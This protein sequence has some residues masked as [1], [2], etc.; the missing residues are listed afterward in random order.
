MG[1]CIPISD[2]WLS[3][4]CKCAVL[5]PGFLF[6][7]KTWSSEI[8]SPLSDKIQSDA[9]LVFIFAGVSIAPWWVVSTARRKIQLSNLKVH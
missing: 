6:S 5:P 4:N 1:V 9:I 7:P 2:G 3:T 8:E